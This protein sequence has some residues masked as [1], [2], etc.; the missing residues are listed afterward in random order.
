LDLEGTLLLDL[1]GTLLLDL[2]GTLFATFFEKIFLIG[3]IKKNEMFFC[4]NKG[5][6]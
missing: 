3:K 5:G 6:I 1:E 2:E 4:C